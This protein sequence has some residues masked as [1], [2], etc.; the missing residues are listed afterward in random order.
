MNAIEAQQYGKKIRKH[1]RAL[2]EMGDVAEWVGSAC[3]W[4]LIEKSDKLG[5]VGADGLVNVSGEVANAFRAGFTG[6]TLT[7]RRA[8]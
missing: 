2:V 3:E 6:R 8:A 5:I 7:G 1:A 4:W